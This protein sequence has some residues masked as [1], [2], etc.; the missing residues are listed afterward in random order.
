M[1]RRYPVKSMGGEALTSV[2]LDHRGI[3]G[4]RWYAVSDEDGRLASGKSTSRFRRRD[5]VFEYAARTDRGRVIVTGPRESWRVGDADLDREL[6]AAMDATVRVSAEGEAPHQDAGQVSLVGTASLEWCRH[7][8]EVDVDPRRLRP[9]VVVATSVPFI[10]ETWVDM[11]LAVGTAE[12]HV[13]ERIERCRMT[14]LAQD[15]LSATTPLLAAL[16][17]ER[18]LRLGV[19]CSVEKPGRIAVGDRTT[20]RRSVRRAAVVDPSRMV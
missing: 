14:D 17:T 10:E 8:L 15:G 5:A 7:H 20:V 18:D 19:Y 6:S 13:V 1:L 3:V 12:L 4:D 11:T 9:N 16:A 2:T